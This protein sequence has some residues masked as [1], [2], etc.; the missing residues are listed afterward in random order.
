MEFSDNG[1]G[2]GPTLAPSVPEDLRHAIEP[3]VRGHLSRLIYDIVRITQHSV[4]DSSSAT[5]AARPPPVGIEYIHGLEPINAQIAAA[6]DSAR[7][8]ILTAQPGGPR[9][10]AV[11]AA[12]LNAV[13]DRIAAGVGMRTLYQHSTR[14]DEATKDY[15]RAVIKLG[16][17]LRTLDEFFERLVIIDRATAFLPATPDRTT[18]LKITEPALARFLGDFFDRTWERAAAFPFRPNRARDAASEIMPEIRQAIRRL[19]I[20]GHA[21]KT[22]GRRLGISERTISAHV[23]W[24]RDSVGAA[25]RLQLGYRLAEEDLRPSTPT[26]CQAAPNGSR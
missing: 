12:A 10:Q 4:G 20:E 7:Y 15:A 6:V 16:A 8:E 2:D 14:F 19:L 26:A 25:N 3:V 21:D 24:L 11:L 23:A 13:R 18:A 5:P 9:P 1:P 22:I 17:E